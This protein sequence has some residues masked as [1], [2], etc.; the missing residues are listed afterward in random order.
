M[1]MR[2]FD[3]VVVGGGLAG[4]L[5]AYEANQA[6]KSVAIYEAGEHCGGAIASIK[7]AGFQ[8]D[9]GA[10]SFATTRPETLALIEELGLSELVVAPARSD[11]RIYTEGQAF[12][13]PHGMMGIPSDL[14]DAQT[15]AIL[16]TDAAQLAVT[17]DSQPW[18]ITKEQTLGDVV[19]KRLGAAVVEKIVNPIV[20]GVHASDSY[21]L[22]MESLL[23]GLLAKAEELG[24]LH[25]AV[26]L[27]RGSA[28]RPGSAVAGINGGINLITRRLYA[29]LKERGVQIFQQSPV[30][31]A[32]FNAVW[33]IE[34]KTENVQADYLVI[35]TNPVIA[36]SIL[37]DFPDIA[38]LLSQINPIDV[39]LVLVAVKAPELSAQP[40]GSGV[41]V[42]DQGG[43]LIA[44]ASTHVSAKWEWVK[45]LVGDLEIVRLSYGRN[46]VVDSNDEH[47]L[48]FAQRDLRKLYGLANPEILD[49][50]VVR[51]PKSLIQARVG[52]RDN[53]KKLDQTLTNHPGLM[54]VG[55]AVSGNGIAGVIGRTRT[56]MKGL[57]SV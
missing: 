24:S 50:V 1:F 15:I 2:R 45:K 56:N 19:A 55:S 47:L 40:L 30:S 7:I 29:L 32:S 26:K 11:A 48:E 53:L 18:N 10:E 36:R 33:T 3:C 22:E 41:L 28:S 20:S 4:L 44:K 31:H 21:L 39:A 16:G 25:K 51:W 42:A 34:T 37:A 46:G 6:G 49:S 8:V 35:A 14:T 9:A 27:M 17:L 38:S 43:E 23:P 57:L 13:I 5:A 12:V 52:H 54:I